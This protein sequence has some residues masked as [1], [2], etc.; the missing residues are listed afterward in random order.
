MV[1]KLCSADKARGLLASDTVL[2]L[3]PI[4][5]VLSCPIF[6]EDTQGNLKILGKGYHPENGGVYVITDM[7]IDE[8]V[9]IEK[10]RDGLL[11]LISEFL[12][13]TPSDKARG[14][15][16]LIAPPFRFGRLIPAD[17]P[18]N[19]LEADVEQTGKTHFIKLI[20]TL[21]NEK[22]FVITGKDKLD[23]K[24][25][26]GM[27]S[28]L[29]ESAVRGEGSVSTRSAYSKVTKTPTGHIFW[30]AT[31]NKTQ[32]SPDLAARS[33][34]IRIKKQPDDYVWKIYPEGGHLAH[35]E[36]KR[37]TYLSYVFAFAQSGSRE[38]NLEH[39][40]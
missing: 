14:L 38:A 21:Y 33:L 12:F 26:T 16:T 11:E 31:S 3:E 17:F 10:A 8:H 29:F 15:A 20:R 39:R 28:E 2:M 34:I 37:A 40:R 13:L 7:V 23:E 6:V 30:L 36:K 9:P 24:L 35:T 4:Q 27:E 25:S 1:Q 18:L 32:M 19:T 22:P 5:A